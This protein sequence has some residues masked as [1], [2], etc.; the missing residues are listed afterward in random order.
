MYNYGEMKRRIKGNRKLE[1]TRELACHKDAENYEFGLARLV[2]QSE[3]NMVRN[4]DCFWW[5]E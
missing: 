2:S 1:K 4:S 3:E 5:W